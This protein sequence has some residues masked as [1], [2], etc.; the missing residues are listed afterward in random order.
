[1]LKTAPTVASGDGTTSASSPLI[2]SGANRWT[3]D[4]GAMP[5]EP[6]AFLDGD[7][8][9]AKASM[10]CVQTPGKSDTFE[11]RAPGGVLLAKTNFASEAARLAELRIPPTVSSA[12]AAAHDRLEAYDFTNQPPCLNRVV[13]AMKAHVLEMMRSG[14][15]PP[16]TDSLSAL[17]EHCDGNCLGGICDDDVF[18]QL[19]HAFGGRDEEESLPRA[20]NQF[21]QDAENQVSAWL[22]S[23]PGL[24]AAS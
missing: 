10:A 24:Q 9:T 23:Q 20:M 3:F 5:G 13:S 17:H 8:E 16:A 4:R 21:L 2:W 6:F 18:E 7:I 1:M 19:V 15:V 14:Q 11:V 22:A 12:C